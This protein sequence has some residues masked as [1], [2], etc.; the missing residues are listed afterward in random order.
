[1]FSDPSK[2]FQDTESAK[3]LSDIASKPKSQLGAYD[4]III[5]QPYCT[6][7]TTIETVP[8]ID[9]LFTFLENS[10]FVDDFST[11]S[12]AWGDF[13]LWFRHNEKELEY[14]GEKKR[15]HTKI[16]KLFRKMCTYG[17]EVGYDSLYVIVKKI[18]DAIECY[19]ES[20]PIQERTI[21]LV[22]ILNI[23]QESDI[24]RGLIMLCIYRNSCNRYNNLKKAAIFE[25]Y[26]LKELKSILNDI[27][28]KI[29]KL[30]CVPKDLDDFL[31]ECEGYLMF[32]KGL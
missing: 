16:E 22:S 27:V 29:L 4:F 14:L 12:T 18:A 7:G 25:A 23:F 26:S 20:V 28:D 15:I 24:L 17:N 31:L 3:L 9:S 1:M 10:Y 13:N 6:P 8:F 19:V 11:V 21:Y 30:Q 5:F 2:D 32:E